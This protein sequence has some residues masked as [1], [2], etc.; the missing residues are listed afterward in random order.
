MHAA[1]AANERF[2]QLLFDSGGPGAPRALA[3]RP[4][5]VSNKVCPTHPKKCVQFPHLGII[6]GRVY[7]R[8]EINRF[9]G[10]HVQPF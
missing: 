1:N 7:C 2:L 6:M 4:V 3:R 5:P 8:I 10:C 9:G